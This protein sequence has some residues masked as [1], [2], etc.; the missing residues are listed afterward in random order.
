M[1]LI[2]TVASTHYDVSSDISL[3]EPENMN[4]ATDGAQMLYKTVCN[5][6]GNNLPVSSVKP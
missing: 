5:V 3:G 2:C 4:K 1:A 6:L